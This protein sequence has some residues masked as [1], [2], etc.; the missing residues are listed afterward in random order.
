LSQKPTRR[1]FIYLNLTGFRK[2][3]LEAIS[4]GGSGLVASAKPANLIHGTK[5]ELKIYARFFFAAKSPAA[6]IKR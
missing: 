1:L 5:M 4:L 3:F 2:L 6:K